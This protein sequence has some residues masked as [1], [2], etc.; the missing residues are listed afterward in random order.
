MIKLQK[1]EVVVIF[2]NYKNQELNPNYH[3]EVSFP[4]FLGQETREL[5]NLGVRKIVLVGQ[6][7][8]W[9]VELPKVL[10]RRFVRWG[11]PVPERTYEGVDQTSLE[12]DNALKRQE[13]SSHVK[14]VSLRDNFCNSSGC[15]V[16]VGPTVSKDLVVFDRGHL[17]QSGSIF[18]AKNVL[19]KVIP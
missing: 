10:L 9:E 11:R 12:V 13:Y 7:P 3:E 6:I 2:F 19:S 14:Y 15:L 4:E 17:T 5:E 18:V 1:P 16:K 8:M